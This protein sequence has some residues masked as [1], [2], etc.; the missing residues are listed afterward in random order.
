MYNRKMYRRQNLYLSNKFSQQQQQQLFTK[1]RNLCNM[2]E[3]FIMC[4]RKSLLFIC[5]H[6]FNQFIGLMV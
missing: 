2:N 6:N 1:T 3:G 5:F 4:A